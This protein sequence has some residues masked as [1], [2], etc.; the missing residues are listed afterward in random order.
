LFKQKSGEYIWEQILRL[1][2]NG[3]RNIKPHQAEFIDMVPLSGDSMF[4]M[5]APS[6]GK[7]IKIK[8]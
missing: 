5:Q 1:C 7:D 2:Y 3:R 8:S 6:I 4:N